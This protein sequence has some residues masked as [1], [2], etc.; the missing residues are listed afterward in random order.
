MG[1]PQATMNDGDGD[2][3]S[4]WGL[5][6]RKDSKKQE[7]KAKRERR[8]PSPPS[9]DPVC[10][11]SPSSHPFYLLDTTDERQ[12]RGKRKKP[13]KMVPSLSVHVLP[14]LGRITDLL[15]RLTGG[16]V[17]FILAAWTL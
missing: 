11:S 5:G 10:G 6:G 3:L 7:G 15:T 1:G 14:Q 9:S 17:V 13:N 16:N 4:G 2:G 8:C 12:Q